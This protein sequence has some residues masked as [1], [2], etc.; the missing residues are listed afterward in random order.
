MQ[1][2]LFIRFIKNQC[3]PEEL[4]EVIKWF[5]GAAGTI[6]G[7]AFL[8]QIW[9]ETDDPEETNQIDFERILDKVHHTLNIIHSGKIYSNMAQDLL[10]K[11]HKKTFD[12]ILSELDRNIFTI[13]CNRNCE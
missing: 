9:N 3:T 12:K 2:A 5:E 6:D 1:K 13:Q 8:K 10:R 11:N 4:D 7:R